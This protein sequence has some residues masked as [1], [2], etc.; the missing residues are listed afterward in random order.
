MVEDDHG[1][2]TGCDADDERTDDE[3][4]RLRMQ[5]K[6][7]MKEDQEGPLLTQEERGMA[8]QRPYSSFHRKKAYQCKLLGINVLCW[9]SIGII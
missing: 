7:E 9:I 6:G 5:R 1:P 8:Q 2:K 4:F 3:E